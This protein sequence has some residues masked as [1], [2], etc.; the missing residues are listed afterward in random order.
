MMLIIII[1]I[2]IIVLLI[3]IIGINDASSEGTSVKTV[4]GLLLIVFSMTLGNVIQDNTS[5]DP[6]EVYRGNT[7]MS[8]KYEILDGDTIKCDTIISRKIDL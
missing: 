1:I 6:I 5:I 4:I 3:L 2:L 7:T 8:I